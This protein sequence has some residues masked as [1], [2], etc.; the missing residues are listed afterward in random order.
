MQATVSP[1]FLVE[2]DNLPEADYPPEVIERWGKEADIA[3]LE[4]ANGELV[5]E[6]LAAFAAE[7]GLKFN[8]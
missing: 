2:L 5:P 3:E 7:H 8:A 4:I 1:R 6:D